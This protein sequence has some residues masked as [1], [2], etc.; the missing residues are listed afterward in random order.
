MLHGPCTSWNEL[1]WLYDD[2]NEIKDRALFEF[3]GT[4]DFSGFEVGGLEAILSAN[5]AVFLSEFDL[6]VAVLVAEGII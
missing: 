5:S 6:D 2:N 1:F 3:V 4:L